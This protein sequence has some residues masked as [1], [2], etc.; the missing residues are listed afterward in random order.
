MNVSFQSCHPYIRKSVV[1]DLLLYNGERGC[2]LLHT[3]IL[4]DV[5]FVYVSTARN[6]GSCFVPFS[7]ATKYVNDQFVPRFA[8]SFGYTSVYSFRAT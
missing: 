2:V 5:M 3:Q 6:S 8:Q 7:H 4:F 1:S